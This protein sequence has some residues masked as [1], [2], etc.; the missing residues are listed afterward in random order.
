MSK[1]E[2]SILT[3]TKNLKKFNSTSEPNPLNRSQAFQISS[4]QTKV[5][6][7]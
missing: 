4:P 7:R 3:T 6:G 2:Q 5:T 1:A